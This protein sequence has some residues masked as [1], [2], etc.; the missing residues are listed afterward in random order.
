MMAILAIS[1][2]ALAV[3]FPPGLM[4]RGA[5]PQPSGSYSSPAA[6]SAPAGPASPPAA[7]S[8]APHSGLRFGDVVATVIPFGG[9]HIPLPSG[10]W[11]VVASLPGNAQ[12][13]MAI[14]M[15]ALAREE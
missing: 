10:Q 7:S 1:A 5:A 14:D 11:Q 2:T 9:R 8:A 4:R 15:E 3:L 6:S 12:N 13:G